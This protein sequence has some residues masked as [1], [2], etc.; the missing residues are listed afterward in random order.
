MTVAGVAALYTV[1]LVV[2]GQEPVKMV[3]NT[4][5]PSPITD[6]SF[7]VCETEVTVPDTRPTQLGGDA[8]NTG[9]VTEEPDTRALNLE[10]MK[11]DNLTCRFRLPPG[12]ERSP[13]TQRKKWTMIGVDSRGHQTREQTYMTAAN[14]LDDWNRWSH[15]DHVDFYEDIGF[16]PTAAQQLV[17]HH[18]VFPLDN[19]FQIGQSNSDP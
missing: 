15:D 3:E 1:Y 4:T 9:T 10:R 12:Q 14:N 18:C 17:D 5:L 8:A 16:P 7:K 6:S 19:Q 13:T 2:N 11:H